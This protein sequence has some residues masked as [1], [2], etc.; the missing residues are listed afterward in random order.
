MIILKNLKKI[1]II[2]KVNK[3]FNV[4]KTKFQIL[5]NL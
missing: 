4:N 1:I 3:K 5:T 2:T